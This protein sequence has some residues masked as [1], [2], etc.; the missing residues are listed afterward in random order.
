F[1]PESTHECPD[2][3]GDI[4][5][6]TGGQKNLDIH[7]TSEPCHAERGQQKSCTWPKPKPEAKLNWSLHSFFKAKATSNP[8]L[9]SV[10]APIHAPKVGAEQNT[11]A[12]NNLRLLEVMPRS[13]FTMDKAGACMIAS[14]LL[15]QL[16]IAI[17]QIPSD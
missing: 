3:G 7:C 16:C 6:G 12:D 9:V 10:P 15:S 1:T 5:V 14:K 8:P 2:C 17:E 4:Q 13:N 11:D